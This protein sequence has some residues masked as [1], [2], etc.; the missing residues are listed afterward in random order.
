LVRIK[1]HRKVEGLIKQATITKTKS[2]EY[3]VSIMVETD[4]VYES[5]EIKSI[6]ALDYKSD[7]LYVDRNGVCNMPHFYKESQEKLAKLQ[8]QLSK[9]KK[10][11]NNY[12]KQKKKLAKFSEHVSNQILD[13]LH[14]ESTKIT[15]L[16][17]AVIVEDIDLKEISSSKS[18]YHLGKATTDNGYGMFVSMLDYK[19]KRKG[20]ILI[21]ADKYFASSQIC[22][23]CGYQN[24]DVKD[25][26]V[27]NWICPKCKTNHDRDKNAVKNLLNYGIKYLES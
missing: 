18:K 26:S 1:K 24:K 6:N 27:R 21:K 7:G 12:N 13:F 9:K 14:K 4:K 17:D 23:C 2:G 10:G 8:R 20:G 5:K 22:S 11:S 3:Y 19:L 16:Y 15:N 25:L